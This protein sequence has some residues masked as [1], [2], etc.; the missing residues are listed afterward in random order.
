MCVCVVAVQAVLQ[1]T[2]AAQATTLPPVDVR[3]QHAARRAAHG[4]A[5]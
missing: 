2:P 4:G 1:P 3:A 5:T